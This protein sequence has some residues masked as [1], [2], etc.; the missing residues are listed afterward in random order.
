MPGKGS[1]RFSKRRKSMRGLKT[2]FVMAA[3]LQVLSLSVSA[4]PVPQQINYQGRLTDSLGYSVDGTFIMQFKITDYPSDQVE[5]TDE[6]H[7][8]NGTTPSTLAHGNIFAMSDVVTTVSGATTYA[9]GADYTMD[10]LAGTIARVGGGAIPDPGDVLVDYWYAQMVTVL[11]SETQ[12]VEVNNGIYDVRLGAFN[13]IPESAFSA[14]EAYLEVNVE[15]ERLI[16]RQPVTSVPY[17]YFAQSVPDGPGSGLDADLLDSLD[18][19]AFALDGHTHGIYALDGHTHDGSHITSGTIGNAF[20]SAYSDLG[21]EAYL[22][23]DSDSDLL[24]RVQLD[25][26]Y[27]NNTSDSMS[28]DLTIG[29]NLTLSGAFMGNDSIGSEDVSF[30]Y[31][32]S[33]SKGGPASDLDCIDCVSASEVQFN[34]AEGFTEGGAATGLAC[35]PACVSGVEIIDN[36]L[37]DTQIQD[38]YV[39]NT[40]DTMSGSLDIGF[41]LDVGGNID[42]AGEIRVGIADV[43]TYDIQAGGQIYA[44]DYIV[45]IGGIH[46]GGET[47]PGTDDLIVDGHIGIG[48][49]PLT[50]TGIRLPSTYAYDFGGDFFGS[51]RGLNGQASGSNVGSIIG[52]RGSAANSNT[53]QS[54]GGYFLGAGTGTGENYGIYAAGTG[55]GPNYGVFASGNTWSGWFEGGPMH[56]GN[57]GTLNWASSDGDIYVED[58]LEVDGDLWLEGSMLCTAC[59]GSADVDFNYAGSSSQGGAATSASN[60]SCSSCVSSSEVSFN[61]AGSTSKGGPASD[62][63]CTDCVSSSEVQFPWAAG[64]TEGGAATNLAC[65]PACVSGVEVV[66]DTLGATQIQDIYVFN[67]TD[68]MSGSLTLGGDLTVSGNN[69]G[70]GTT[71]SSSYGILNDVGSAP[72]YGAHLMGTIYGVRGSNA[73]NVS[74]WGRLGTGTDGLESYAGTSSDTGSRY[75]IYSYARST[76]TTYGIYAR[77]T[78]YGTSNAYGVYGYGSNSG[79]GSSYGIYSAAGT[80]AWVNPDPEDPEK[81]IVYATIEGGE[82]G[83]YWRGTARMTDGEAEVVLPDH[84]RKVTSPDHPVTVTVTPRDECNGIRLVD[85]SNDKILVK[86]LMGGQSNARFDFIVMGKRLG[87]EDFEPIQD[88]IDYVPFQGNQERVDDTETTTQDWYDAQ[89]PGL[90]KIFKKNGI[91]DKE[92]KVNEK[93]FKEKGWKNVKEKKPKK[94]E[95]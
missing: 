32:A 63:A 28:G 1:N 72:S 59:I 10:Y 56:V 17:A 37:N 26:R 95:L 31:A 6:P 38:I 54:Y 69:I 68:S 67:T 12:A 70:L 36:D 91:L 66:D 5:I 9:R 11:W 73:N 44:A 49:D 19:S 76:S 42:A 94:D 48:T 27:L 8:L 89:S 13:P 62:L 15:G 75:G 74:N 71:P 65:S 55:A 80:K 84:F 30:K 60:L 23:N 25:G 61:Y 85:A 47:D 2:V 83:T 52:V 33:A 77:G 51:S 64:I 43:G 16:P 40:T 21:D 7:T 79:G 45:A 41:H 93:L 78:G 39:F 14:G 35:S 90:V 87:Y 81:S 20:F 34:Y 22:D 46:I 4:Q 18:S 3:V 29:G 82:N 24:T 57:A 92:G 53:G 50:G 58:D 86:E 88:N